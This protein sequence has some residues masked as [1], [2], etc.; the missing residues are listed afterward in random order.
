MAA[1]ITGYLAY[2]EQGLHAGKYP[3]MP[4]FTVASITQTQSR[5]QELRDDL[6]TLIP[7]AAARRAY[8]FIA[9]EDFTLASV[10]P[11]AAVVAAE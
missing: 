2:Y 4:T 7:H 5:A 10:A 9:F 11:I 6:Q 8:P 3:G 1:K